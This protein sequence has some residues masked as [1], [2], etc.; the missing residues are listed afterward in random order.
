MLAPR[1]FVSAILAALLLALGAATPSSAQIPDKFTNLQ[2]VPKDIGRQ[3]LVGMMRNFSGALGV[4][5]SF[6]HVGESTTSLEGFD[7]ASDDKEHKLVAR[8]MMKMVKDINE[9]QLPKTGRQHLLKVDCFTCHRGVQEPER[10]E[11]VLM[12]AIDKGGLSAG[13]ERYRE[14]REEYYGRSA[15]DFGPES[16]EHL[17]EELAQSKNDLDGAVE[18]AKLNV[19]FNPG[20]ARAHLGL[21]QLYSMKGDKQAAITSIERALELEPDNQW[22]KRL[23]ERVRGSK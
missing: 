19:E 9:V 1:A 11:E 10:L 3:E 8:T 23:L 7:F 4:R 6:C 21:G 22:A 12:E 20:A 2:V 13:T 16:L 18:I 5:C 17:A 14:L 15:Y